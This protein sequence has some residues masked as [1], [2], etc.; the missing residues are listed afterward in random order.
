MSK[1]E[2]VTVEQVRRRYEA[3][4]AIR[5]PYTHEEIGVLLRALVEAR[6]EAEQWH[7]KAQ[8]TDDVRL[9][10]VLLEREHMQRER[11]EARAKLAAVTETAEWVCTTLLSGDTGCVEDAIRLAA[12]CERV[13][14]D[15]KAAAEAHDCRV[16]A[17]ALE[18]AAE[19]RL[20]WDAPHREDAATVRRSLDVWL[21]ERAEQIRRDAR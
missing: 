19:D 18:E 8:E 5:G 16:R 2:T 11:D 21:R 9:R 6:E 7:R 13:L 14:A 10:D 1:D 17:E 12:D 20:A 4:L 3:P 15:A